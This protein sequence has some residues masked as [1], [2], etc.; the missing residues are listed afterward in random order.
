MVTAGR[1]EGVSRVER[2]PRRG[3]GSAAGKGGDGTGEALLLDLGGA[4]EGRSHHSL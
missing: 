2:R 4:Y 3:T 1:G